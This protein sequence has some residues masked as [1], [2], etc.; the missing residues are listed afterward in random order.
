MITSKNAVIRRNTLAAVVVL[1]FL[2]AACSQGESPAAPTPPASTPAAEP[3]PP[4]ATPVPPVATSLPTAGEVRVRSVDGMAMVYV[5]GG[6]LQI[7]SSQDSPVTGTEPLDSFWFDRAEVT[8]AQYHQ[9][10]DAGACRVPVTCNLV[11]PILDDPS[12]AQEPIKCAKWSD[13]KAYCEW[14]GGRLPTEAEWDAG[15]AEGQ[16]GSGL[17]YWGKTEFGF[18]CVL[19][20]GQSRDDWPTR[21]WITAAPQTQD[22][23]L[24]ILEKGISLLEQTFPTPHSLL[25]VRHG[26]LVVE[27]YYGL[28]PGT[29]QD[30]ASVGKSVISALVG[31]AIEQGYIKGLDQ[32]IVDYF[33]QAVTPG[34]DPRF[35]DITIRHLL[36]MTP[37]FYWPEEEPVAG[38]SVDKWFGRGCLPED[39]FRLPMIAEPGRAFQYCTACTHL[40]SAILS[41]STGMTARDFAQETLFTPLGISSD[42]WNW[43]A[44][45]YGYNTGGWAIYLTPRDMAK[46]GYLYL[47]HGEWDGKQIISPDW[48]HESTRRQFKFPDS[49][50]EGYGY[51]WVVTNLKG[52]PAYYAKGHGGQY[53][54]V[55]PTLDL[56]V[57]VTQE[58]ESHI[59]G[60]PSQIVGDYIAGSVSEVRGAP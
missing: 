56:V 22:M 51:L 35:N 47:R 8:N 11:E 58:T 15:H 49:R 18:R 40:L 29:Y 57:V 21:G 16:L 54:Y 33:P 25:V 30:V 32:K 44:T 3:G 37:G 59:Y 1:S 12:K 42:D 9:C 2:I 60:D 46:F 50:V 55:L 17:N 48:V 26:Y 38:P 31:I 5:P 7:G 52:H 14:V 24:E 4:T 10:V 6:A 41:I 20:L 27:K 13:A 28:G 34:M 19:P 43:F 36:T 23:D 53:I 39:L 45:S